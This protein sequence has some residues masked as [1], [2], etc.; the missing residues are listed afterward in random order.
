MKKIYLV[1]ADGYQSTCGCEL[2]LLGAFDSLEKA[3]QVK[4]EQE[5]KTVKIIQA[6]INK[7]YS[8]VFD[9]FGDAGNEK[10][11]GGYIE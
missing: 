8:L 10:Y 9:Y 7:T 11:L 6:N 5:I 2:F 3:E 4:Q 1:I